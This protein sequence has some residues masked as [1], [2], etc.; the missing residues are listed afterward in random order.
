MG[1]GFNKQ[2]DMRSSIREREIVQRRGD[3]MASTT[4]RDMF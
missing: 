2:L 3:A 1:A 4:S